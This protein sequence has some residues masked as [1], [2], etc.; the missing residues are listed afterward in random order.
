MVR[1]IIDINEEEVEEYKTI[2]VTTVKVEAF[3]KYKNETKNEIR[4]SNIIEQK[5]KNGKNIEIL[6]CC[7]DKENKD[8]FK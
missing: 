2:K 5:I 8:L 4:V 7:K 6:N 1:I 3:K